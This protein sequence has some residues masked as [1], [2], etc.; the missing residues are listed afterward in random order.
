MYFCQVWTDPGAVMLRRDVAKHVLGTCRN[1]GRALLAVQLVQL[2]AELADSESGV[3]PD[4]T[5]Y[6]LALKSVRNHERLKQ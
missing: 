3:W 4:E 5:A 2:G 6:R 1:Q